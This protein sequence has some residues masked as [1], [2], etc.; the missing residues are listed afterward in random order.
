MGETKKKRNGRWSFT[1][2]EKKKERGR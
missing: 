2:E 1:E